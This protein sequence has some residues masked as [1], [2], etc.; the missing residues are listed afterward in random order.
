MFPISQ[1]IRRWIRGVLEV[2]G[3]AGNCRQDTVQNSVQNTETHSQVLKGDNQ[4]QRSCG[5]LQHC[6]HDH[7]MHEMSC[8]NLQH[9]VHDHVMH[10]GCAGNCNG[11]MPKAPC[12]TVLF[13]LKTNVLIWGL[14][15]ST[16]M[17]TAIILAW[18]MIKI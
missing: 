2:E 14:F 3:T 1:G 16:T 6:A 7:V 13:D 9:C 15:M 18:N 5:K 17:K 12:L 11:I 4:S 10:K 8:G